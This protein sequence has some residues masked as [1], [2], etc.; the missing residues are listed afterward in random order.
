MAVVQIR[1]RGAHTTFFGTGNGMPGDQLGRYGAIDLPRRRDY[2]PLYAGDIGQ[3]HRGIRVRA[4]PAENFRETQGGHAD[5]HQIA[6]PELGKYGFQIRGG[7]IDHP[8]PQ[9]LLQGLRAARTAD[10]F[11]EQPTAPC[12]QRQ[13]AAH[14]PQA[15][16]QQTRA[17][18][19]PGLHRRH[20]FRAPRGDRSPEPATPRPGERSRRA[21]GVLGNRRDDPR[22]R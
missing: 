20:G 16:D 1:P 12:R 14:Q 22:S 2:G 8:F 13:A 7:P 3:G 21:S 5:R 11:T 18:H 17:D 9:P 19:R 6:G 4:D 10:D 15:H